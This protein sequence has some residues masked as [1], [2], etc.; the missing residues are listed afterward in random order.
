MTRQELN[1]LRRLIE[2]ASAS[3]SDEDA[4]EAPVLFPSWEIGKAY[5]VGDRVDYEDV[6]YKVNQAHTSQ[7]DWLPSETP[8]LYSPVTKPGEIDVWHQPQGAHDAY[9]IGDLVY[10][11]TK[12]DPIYENTVANNVYAPDVYGWVLHE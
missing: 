4:L 2:K 8:A 1:K 12:E 6:L 9:Q 11:P 7:A 10:Y 5:A 3:L